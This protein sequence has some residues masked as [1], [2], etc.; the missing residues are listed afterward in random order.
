MVDDMSKE[1][2]CNLSVDKKVN[3]NTIFISLFK[4]LRNEIICYSQIYIIE[5][6]NTEI[7]S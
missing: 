5:K 6:P 2:A 7:K 1:Y 3:K 4:K